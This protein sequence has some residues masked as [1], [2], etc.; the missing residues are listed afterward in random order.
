M[1]RYPDSASGTVIDTRKSLNV[2][3]LHSAVFS[4]RERKEFVGATIKA[5][6]RDWTL[7]VCEREGAIAGRRERERLL[8]SSLV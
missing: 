2:G 8:V 7:C 6:R 3:N 1:A 4:R 5:N